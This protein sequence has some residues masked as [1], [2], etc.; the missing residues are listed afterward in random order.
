[1]GYIL[2]VF[3]DAMLFLPKASLLAFYFRMLPFTERRTRIALRV[4]I[5]YNIA[6]FICTMLL[7]F[8]WCAPF[9]ENW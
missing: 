5:A 3:F 1:M 7:D 2:T 4:V 8:F 6:A 9:S